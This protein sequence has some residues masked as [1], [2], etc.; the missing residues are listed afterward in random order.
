MQIGRRRYYS[1]ELPYYTNAQD[2]SIYNKDLP[3]SVDSAYFATMAIR[4]VIFNL[5]SFMSMYSIFL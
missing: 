1:K 3:E 5:E 2:I 4:I